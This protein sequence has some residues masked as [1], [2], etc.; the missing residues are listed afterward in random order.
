VAAVT[1]GSPAQQAGL[2]PLDSAKRTVGDIIVGLNGKPV[3]TV[4]DL[5]SG[6]D[7]V[8]VGNEAVLTVQRGNQKREV[9][10]RVIDLQDR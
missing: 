4:A 9:K 8:G 1:P 7:E 10:V 3:L 2:L 6:L 5:A